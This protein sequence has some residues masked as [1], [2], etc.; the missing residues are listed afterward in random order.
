MIY[1]E[2]NNGITGSFE[3]ME[4]L[5]DEN[6]VLHHFDSWPD[7]FQGALSYKGTSSSTS[8]LAP[9]AKPTWP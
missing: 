5:L 4:K 2:H 3:F 6:Q 8:R 9:Q 7:R 1:S